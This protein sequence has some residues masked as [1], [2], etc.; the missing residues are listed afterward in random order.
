MY[1]STSPSSRTGRLIMTIIYLVAAAVVVCGCLF[2][3]MR[4]RSRD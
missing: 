3:L 2:F 1:A 4:A